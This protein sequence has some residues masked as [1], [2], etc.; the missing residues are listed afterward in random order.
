MSKF[1]HTTYLIFKPQFSY[2][3]V[4][5]D[6]SSTHK[7]MQMKRPIYAMV[8]FRRHGERKDMRRK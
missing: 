3:S 8:S 5:V 2:G 7:I 1:L 4:H 6:K